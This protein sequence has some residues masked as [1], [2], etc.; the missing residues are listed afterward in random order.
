MEH[1]TFRSVM[2]IGG[3]VVC[4]LILAFFTLPVFSV[5]EDDVPIYEAILDKTLTPDDDGEYEITGYDKAVYTVK[6]LL[7]GRSQHY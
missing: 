6:G 7:R 1:N 4:G 2:M 5:P 3:V